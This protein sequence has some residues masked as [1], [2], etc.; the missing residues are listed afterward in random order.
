[1]YIENKTVNSVDWKKKQEREGV[2]I[3]KK[4]KI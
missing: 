2:F 4:P 3:G 1:M